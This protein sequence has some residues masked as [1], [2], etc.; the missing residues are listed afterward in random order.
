MGDE[1]TR[2]ERP[3]APRRWPKWT[4]PLLFLVLDTPWTLAL[5][6]GIWVSFTATRL[7]G[8]PY[9]RSVPPEQAATCQ[10]V[11]FLLAILFLAGR[12]TWTQGVRRMKAL[13][14]SSTRWLRAAA[15][16]A[17]RSP[18]LFAFWVLAT[19]LRHI[20]A[21]LILLTLTELGV[22]LAAPPEPV[23]VESALPWILILWLAAIGTLMVGF[24]AL[25]GIKRGGRGEAWPLAR[26]LGWVVAGGAAS[27]LAIH[28]HREESRFREMRQRIDE[29][30]DMTQKIDL[31]EGALRSGPD[32][33][34]LR[35]SREL[36]GLAREARPAVPS[37]IG[38]LG[39]RSRG[40]RYYAAVALGGIGDSSAIPALVEASRRR[41]SFFGLEDLSEGVRWRIGDALSKME[42][43]R[44][45]PYLDDAD[46][47]VRATVLMSFT[48]GDNPRHV[49]VDRLLGSCM[50]DDREESRQAFI[51]LR[52]RSNRPDSI[53]PA[54]IERLPR[55]SPDHKR[56]IAWFFHECGP[57]AGA[58]TGVLI[59]WLFAPDTSLQY[60]A[61][62]ALIAIGP[63]AYEALQK[64]RLQ[65]REEDLPRL[66]GVLVHI[67]RPIPPPPPPPGTKV[68]AEPDL[69]VEAGPTY[70]LQVRLLHDSRPLSE[71][72][73]AVPEVKI[74]DAVT[75]W[76]WIKGTATETPSL[77]L[78]K[79]V[80][81]GSANISATVT[82]EGVDY[83]GGRTLTVVDGP[84]P[85]IDVEL[86]RRIRLLEPPEG[87]TIQES[88]PLLPLP[89][90]FR[91]ESL[92]EGVEY[93]I[94]FH[95]TL[96]PIYRDFTTRE[97]SI[98]F[99]E[100]P[101]PYEMHLSALRGKKEIGHITFTYRFR[102][103][104]NGTERFLTAGGSSF[105]FRM[106]PAEAAPSTVM[107]KLSHDGRAFD[108]G[109]A[110]TTVT[111]RD[112][113]R[114]QSLA[115]S[116]ERNGAMFKI[117]GLPPGVFQVILSVDADRG[118]PPGYAGDYAGSLT[119]GLR[120]DSNPE[121]RMLVTRILR[122][123]KPEDTA[124]PVLAQ[125]DKGG[126]PAFVSPVEFEWEGLG[127]D[128]TYEYTLS[129]GSQSYGHTRETRLQLEVR[130]GQGSESFSLRAHRKGRLIGELF[131]GGER[132]AYP[133][134][135]LD[136]ER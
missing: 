122:L 87:T 108:P 94:F 13:A 16:W 91:W 104:V 100:S 106:M 14:P 61:E 101:G 44:I 28:T 128:V 58:A 127:D 109:P 132:K 64:A 6:A 80:S 1:P 36:Y 56:S 41:E 116:L 22:H 17:F 18:C 57:R 98:D 119:F 130:P 131:I 34:S 15:L 135:A 2:E 55:A 105:R 134:F 59:E 81:P 30:S 10:L 9:F 12:R 54:L 74:Q 52:S 27:C 76:P 110:P 25:W 37:L 32:R 49:P 62:E 102:H 46:P 114:V 97:T 51:I 65:R 35:A 8:L 82:S 5:L 69:R 124:R 33:L 92:G 84:N 117:K 136:R 123:L 77:F 126:P 115:P 31:L 90:R 60:S 85:V 21:F 75:M 23:L 118:N 42:P 113:T 71:A 3:L 120:P 48:R 26:A 19:S 45:L 40:V 38:A 79:G 83:S 133:F 99:D 112:L 66:A 20:G 86:L 4:W 125:R 89:A 68:E 72:T 129:G 103:V 47:V 43:W 53:L 29:T 78:V 70:S 50:S 67:P 111:V 96:L 95:G 24:R 39:S 7:L 88:L 93:R 107:L 11:L 63:E 73:P 121:R